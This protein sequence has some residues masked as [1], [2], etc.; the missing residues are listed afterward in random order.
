MTNAGHRVLWTVVALL[1]VAAGGA[2]LAVNLGRWPGAD[3]GGMLLGPGVRRAWRLAAPWGTLAAAVAGLL[4]AL[5]GQRLLHRELRAARAPARRTLVHP[6]GR[7]GRTRVAAPA[8]AR[9]LERDLTGDPRIRRARVVL[10]GDPPRPDLWIRVDIEAGTR[11]AGLREHV[12]TA[13]R[14]Y[15]DTAG[16]R[17]AHLDVTARID[18]G[19]A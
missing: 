2:V 3:P 11:T 8:L 13:I 7:H 4:L 9:A 19:R 12:S 17:P 10:T 14:R 18:N 6:A 5:A 16:C 1:L 15:V